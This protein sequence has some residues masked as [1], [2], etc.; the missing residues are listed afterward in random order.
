MTRMPA[1]PSSRRA[2]RRL[3]LGVTLVELLVAIALG[4]FI[5][6]ALIT[7]YVNVIRSNSEMS[8]TN[9]LIENGRFAM[10]ILQEDAAL[11]GFW[12]PIEQL[13]ATAVPDPC[14]AY[15]AG[16]TAAYIVNALAVPVQGFE[17][18]TP[19]A[20]C[21]AGLASVVAR[22]DVLF[23]T[24]ASTCTVGTG[25]E[26]AGDTGP[27]IQVSSCRT[28]PTPEPAYVVET[29][30]AMDA[31]TPPLR[32]R[33]CL[34]APVPVAEQAPR[35]KVVSNIYYVANNASGVPTLM[36]MSYANGAYGA[37]QALVEGIE[38]FQ[39]EFGIDDLGSNGLPISATNPADGNADRYKS[40]TAATP[41]SLADLANV[42]SVKL[43]LLA[44]N[45]EP[46]PGYS[47]A[48]AYTVGPLAVP[49]ANDAYK[50]H[51]FSTTVRL[52]N[53]SSRREKP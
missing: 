21:G 24:R 12:G 29:T 14:A 4:L 49:A 30:A 34:A 37:G 10:Q 7:L 6:M 42:V 9:Q 40:C 27:H 36:R 51:V 15:P 1:F 18:G 20:A 53:P 35:R 50:R 26:G 2:A 11:A 17:N 39:V 3:A 45:L 5:V 25:C 13:E 16:W 48:K 23:V 38:A 31:R 47:D 8:R 41:C 28:D 44:R 52:V 22:S 46:T 43:H 19:Y 33:S 32:K